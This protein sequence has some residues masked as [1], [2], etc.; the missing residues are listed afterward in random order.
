MQED[1]QGLR[2]LGITYLVISCLGGVTSL[3][4]AFYAP[5]LARWYLIGAA[6]GLVLQGA[7]VNGVLSWMSQV[8][9]DTTA[10]RAGLQKELADLKRAVQDVNAALYRYPTTAPTAVAPAAPPSA[11][12]AVEDERPVNA[13]KN[14]GLKASTLV[15]QH[16]VRRCARCRTELRGD[17]IPSE[18]PGCGA[19][20]LT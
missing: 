11:P 8:A 9:A 2:G 17:T 3:V 10:M 6:A 14:A 18:C 16:G 1:Q 15:D 7:I 5:G 12:R 13:P 4:A 19:T 20:L